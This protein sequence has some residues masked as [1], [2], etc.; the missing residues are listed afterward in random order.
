MINSEQKN[1]L[2]S[3]AK[4]FVYIHGTLK[5]ESMFWMMFVSH[6]RCI[7]CRNALALFPGNGLDGKSSKCSHTNHP[8][9]ALH[10]LFFRITPLFGYLDTLW[11]HS[12]NT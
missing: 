2:T 4:V 9:L 10:Q 5:Y 3:F 1:L 6:F 12:N 8:Y 7:G 11:G